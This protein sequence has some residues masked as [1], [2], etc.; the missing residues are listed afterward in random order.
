MNKN[1]KRV[2]L[3]MLLSMAAWLVVMAAFMNFW[4]IGYYGWIGLGG[5]IVAFLASTISI[6]L[7]NNGA[8]SRDTTEINALP[9]VVTISYLI[10]TLVVNTIFCGL[11]YLDYAKFIPIA[12]NLILLIVFIAF[13]SFLDPYRAQVEQ[14]AAAV[15]Q[16][17]NA[18]NNFT[19]LLSE[20]VAVT[21]DADEK[22]AAKK[23]QELVAYSPN[24]S[25]GFNSNTEDTFWNQLSE[26]RNGISNGADKELI[27]KEIAEATKTWNRR[28]GVE[29]SI[30]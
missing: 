17:V 18:H 24:M 9:Y 23:L 20:I 10:I 22:Q 5:G 13:R 27:L 11:Y 15:K 29:G 25:Q 1:A 19:A 28:N 8:P 26:I 3:I 12:V 7:W 14:N 21:D 2:L 6:I 4:L 30:K 16:K